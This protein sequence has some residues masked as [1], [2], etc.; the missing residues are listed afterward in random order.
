M[1]PSTKGVELRVCYCLVLL[2]CFGVLWLLLCYVVSCVKAARGTQSKAAE[3]EMAPSTTCVEFRFCYCFVSLVRSV[4]LFW[5]Y[6]LVFC[7]CLFVLWF[8]LLV[9]V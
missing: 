5:C 1:V 7:V 6:V 4:L 9:C 2:V 3:S 8:I